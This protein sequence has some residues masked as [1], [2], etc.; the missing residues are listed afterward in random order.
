M[1]EQGA[2]RSKETR[3]FRKRLKNRECLSARSKPFELESFR[4]RRTL[5]ETGNR[6]NRNP[7]EF[8]DKEQTAR[9][10]TREFQNKE[11]TARQ[12]FKILRRR[13]KPLES[14]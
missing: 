9:K 2:N 3:E 10:E 6:E 4:T 12:E 14:D 8:E 7:R 13:S 5:L 1:S 11:Q